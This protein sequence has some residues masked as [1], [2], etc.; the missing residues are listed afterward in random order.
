MNL[1]KPI[2]NGKL[3]VRNPKMAATN[4]KNPENTKTTKPSE[5]KSNSKRLGKASKKVKGNRTR[6]KAKGK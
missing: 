4:T 1:K 2:L 5:S 3:K 6:N